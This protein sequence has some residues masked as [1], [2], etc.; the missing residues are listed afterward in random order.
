MNIKNIYNLVNMQQ[1]NHLLEAETVIIPT[2]TKTDDELSAEKVRQL[3][4]MAW[5][6][7]HE[8]N[9]QK[10]LLEQNDHEASVQYLTDAFRAWVKTSEVETTDIWK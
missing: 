3:I 10:G 4:D 1:G 7:I 8:R 9:V 6:V 5:S 2:D